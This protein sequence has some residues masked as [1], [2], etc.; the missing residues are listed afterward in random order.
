MIS[1]KAWQSWS[2]GKRQGSCTVYLKEIRGNF[3]SFIHFVSL[4]IK[5]SWISNLPRGSVYSLHAK[6]CLLIVVFEKEGVGIVF[7]S[8]FGAIVA[9]I[10]PEKERSEAK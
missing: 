6:S 4:H 8:Y 3:H 2:L 7:A 5:S 10:V 9:I 1:K